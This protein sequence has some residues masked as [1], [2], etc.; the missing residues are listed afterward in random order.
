MQ[1]Y[2]GNKFNCAQ[3]NAGGHSPAAQAGS[4]SYPF[5][6]FMSNIQKCLHFKPPDPHIRG[7]AAVYKRPLFPNRFFFFC[8]RCQSSVVLLFT[9]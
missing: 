7:V 3:V 2:I 1:S 9:L 5:S 8:V 6:V 4:I